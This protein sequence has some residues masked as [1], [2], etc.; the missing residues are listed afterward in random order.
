VGFE[1]GASLI[2]TA[3][4]RFDG[5]GDFIEE[6]TELVNPALEP[7]HEWPVFGVNQQGCALLSAIFKKGETSSM[8]PYK[9]IRK[10]W[11]SITPRAQ[12]RFLLLVSRKVL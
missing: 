2:F 10:D 6:A 7:T 8:L 4:S 1:I 12:C 5:L 3:N 11:F 9:R